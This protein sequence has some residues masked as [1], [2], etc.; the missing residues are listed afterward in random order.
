MP[1]TKLLGERLLGAA[2]KELKTAEALRGASAIGLYFSASW[3]PPCRQFTPQL[4]ESYTKSLQPKGFRCVLVSSDHD[5]PSFSEYFS[6]M[7]W[8]ALPYEDRSRKEDLSAAFGVRTIPTLALVDP[9]GKTI[10]TEARDEV[11]KDLEGKGYPWK[12]PAVRDFAHGEVGRLNEL[13]SLILLCEAAEEA[14]HHQMLSDLT[15]VA[16]EWLPTRGPNKEYA[17]FVGSGGPLSE[18]IRQVSG[19]PRHG[20][21][22]LLMIDIKDNGAIFLGPT[23]TSALEEGAARRMLEDFEADKLERKQLDL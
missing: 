10:T 1:L 2:G 19:L 11:V 4:I 18:R 3:C 12:P 21:P 9:E 15:S 17:Y 14:V 8:L 5:E 16:L 20:E 22:Q 13:P 6:K 23:G 7:P